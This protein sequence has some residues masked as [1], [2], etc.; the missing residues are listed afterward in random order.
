MVYEPRVDGF[1]LSR[2]ASNT[3]DSFDFEYLADPFGDRTLVC[4]FA[5]EKMEYIEIEE[6]PLTVS[7]ELHGQIMALELEKLPDIKESETAE[8]ESLTVL[9]APTTELTVTYTNGTT[10]KKAVTDEVVY[11][12]FKIL[13]NYVIQNV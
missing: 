6:T 3:L 1:F 11:K 4:H 10:V 12:L 2:S 8:D 9:D 7:A 5:T 13:T